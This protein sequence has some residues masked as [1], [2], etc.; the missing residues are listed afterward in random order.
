MKRLVF[1]CAV[2][3]SAT[4][5]LSSCRT[6]SLNAP[7]SST[8]KTVKKPI[9]AAPERK[10]T[11]ANLVSLKLQKSGGVVG[12]RSQML[13][14]KRSVQL[15]LGDE[16]EKGKA[17]LR[18]ALSDKELDV[19]LKRLNDAHFTKIVGDY[20]Q[21]GI[22]DA[23]ENVVTVKVKMAGGQTKS[24]VVSNYGEHAPQGFDAI[25]LWLS[26]LRSKKFPNADQ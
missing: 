22:A 16:S 20:N 17:T 24:F 7:V 14:Q 9:Q 21:P 12:W 4:P 8:R 26:N 15:H 18:N 5:L 25:V 11:S 10:I 6:A 13:I 3:F 19:L 1:C 2:A 23:I